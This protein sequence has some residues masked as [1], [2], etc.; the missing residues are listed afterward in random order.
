M[1]LIL[2][3]FSENGSIEFD[4]FLEILRCAGSQNTEHPTSKSTSVPAKNN[5]TFTET[6][7]VSNNVDRTVKTNM[8]VLFEQFDKDNDGRI[9]KTELNFVMKNLFPDEIITD[10]DLDDMLRA[11]DLDKNGFIDFDG[12][13]K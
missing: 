13:C 5:T 9:T 3:I 7:N 6:T 12:N 8:R 1:C 10:R 4:E 11:A 2:F